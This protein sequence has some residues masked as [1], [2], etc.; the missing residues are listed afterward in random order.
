MSLLRYF[1]RPITWPS[2]VVY[3][4]YMETM[5]ESLFK[6]F[7]DYITDLIKKYETQ[8]FLGILKNLSMELFWEQQKQQKW[9]DNKQNIMTHFSLIKIH[10]YIANLKLIR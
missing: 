7:S 3:K 2:P 5:E 9:E 1:G 4:M 6:Y 8:F 10:P